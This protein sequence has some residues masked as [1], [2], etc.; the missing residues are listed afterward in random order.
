M[1]FVA[2]I[3]VRA[4]ANSVERA[5]ATPVPCTR[6]C[7]RA[8]VNS[9]G[10]D[11]LGTAIGNRRLSTPRRLPLQG[12]LDGRATQEP[13]RSRERWRLPH[14]VQGPNQAARGK[15]FSRTDRGGAVLNQMFNTDT[16]KDGTLTLDKPRPP[17][18][19]VKSATVT[20]HLI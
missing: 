12:R 16:N 10:R 8:E 4:D 2:S 13:R 11:G 9:R 20:D 1:R 18:Q 7:W 15:P 17:R 6:L 3:K 5:V 19:M 14:S